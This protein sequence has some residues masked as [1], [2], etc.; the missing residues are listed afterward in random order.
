MKGFEAKKILVV[1]GAGFVGSNL[2]HLLLG[3]K[4]RQV[5]LIGHMV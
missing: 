1:G 4:P 3:H 5:D 2:V